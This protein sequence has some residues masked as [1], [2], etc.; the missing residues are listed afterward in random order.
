MWFTVSPVR[1]RVLV[2]ES[3]VAVAAVV[4]IVNLY[5]NNPFPPA[6]IAEI[7][8]RLSAEAQV[9]LITVPLAG[10]ATHLG[11]DASLATPLSGRIAYFVAGDRRRQQHGVH[12]GT[13]LLSPW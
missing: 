1:K 11:D 3:G 9:Q 8:A 5:F 7:V 12:S 2:E 6:V 4:S 13:R 10:A